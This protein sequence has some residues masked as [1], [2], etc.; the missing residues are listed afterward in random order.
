MSE[1]IDRRRLLTHGACLAAGG[2]LGYLGTRLAPR[3]W[4]PR[5]A[6]EAADETPEQ[7]LKR[8]KITLPEAPAPKG[9]ILAQA[10]R[11]GNMLY[12][13]GNGPGSKDGSPIKGKL[14]KDFSLEDGQDAA[15]RVGLTILSVVRAELGSLDKVVR[16]V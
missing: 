11:S 16:L 8:L 13:S 14:G 9:A 15:R 12:V 7:R 1:K 10:V 2:L 6:A 5:S 3:A 4:T